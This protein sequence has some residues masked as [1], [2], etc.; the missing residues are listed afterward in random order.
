MVCAE[1]VTLIKD[2]IAH[3]PKGAETEEVLVNRLSLALRDFIQNNESS[4]G[5]LIADLDNIEEIK[6]LFPP[7]RSGEQ[8]NSILDER[9]LDSFLGGRR[10]ANGSRRVGCR[11]LAIVASYL[12]LKGSRAFSLNDL[13][14]KF[15]D[16]EFVNGL[17]QLAGHDEIDRESKTVESMSGA[18]LCEKP[19][20]VGDIEYRYL[21]IEKSTHGG[22]LTLIHRSK[23]K[24]K[25]FVFRAEKVLYGHG[26]IT[27]HDNLLFLFKNCVDSTKYQMITFREDEG[28]MPEFIELFSM[29]STDYLSAD[30]KNCDWLNKQRFLYKRQTA[31]LLTLFKPLDDIS[32]SSNLLRIVSTSGTRYANTAEKIEI[33]K[34]YGDMDE[35]KID[36]AEM[37]RLSKELWQLM[38]HDKDRY[39]PNLEKPLHVRIL[40][41]VK[42]GASLN[43]KYKNRC[44]NLHMVARWVAPFPQ[45]VVEASLYEVDF[46][47]RD[48]D[49]YLPSFRSWELY[50]EDDPET[51]EAYNFFREKELEAGKKIGIYPCISENRPL[52]ESSD[53]TGP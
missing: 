26:V 21:T 44:T 8:Y 51:V 5:S 43:Y 27:F 48:H 38:A 35:A 47:Q 53:P 50:D 14:Y 34:E 39:D 42:A 19:N 4:T 1:K 23:F 46:L 36:E 22:H 2:V 31:D 40:D 29:D 41:L 12:L 17:S 32:K 25:D 15:F 13:A 33:R 3:L 9:T 37:E 6:T 30:D 52:Q 28:A 11:T 45:M 49:G 20:T 7:E 24:D 18:Y 16:N 10:N